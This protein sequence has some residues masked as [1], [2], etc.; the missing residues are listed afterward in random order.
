MAPAT[1]ATK[2]AANTASQ[3]SSLKIMVIPLK[4]NLR[5]S[6]YRI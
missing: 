6:G 1:N 2:V 5:S 4:K 3:L